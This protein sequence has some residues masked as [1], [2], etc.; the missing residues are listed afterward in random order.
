MIDKDSRVVA[1][2]KQISTELGGEVAILHLD[3]GIYYSLNEVGA[4]IWA[5]IQR[6]RSVNE[7]LTALSNRYKVTPKECERDLF[8]FL[9]DLQAENLIQVENGSDT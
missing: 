4:G 2:K 8:V 3:S 6:S 9:E 7:I 1:I 5:F